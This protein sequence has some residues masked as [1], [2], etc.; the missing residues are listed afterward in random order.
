VAEVLGVSRLCL[1]NPHREQIALQMFFPRESQSSLE[2][3]RGLGGMV[4]VE[5]EPEGETAQA[6]AKLRK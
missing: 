1:H 3:R 4:S 6:I 5:L 2:R